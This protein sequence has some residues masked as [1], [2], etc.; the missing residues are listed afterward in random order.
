MA[1]KFTK[2]P[3]KIPNDHKLYQYGPFQGA[4]KCTKV[5]IFWQEKIPSGNPGWDSENPQI[6]PSGDVIK[7]FFTKNS[8]LTNPI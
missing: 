7:F 1:R 8:L 5:G 4:P 2:S 3:H 6:C